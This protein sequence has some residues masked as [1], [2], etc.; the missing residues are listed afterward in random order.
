M[1]WTL[2]GPLG[3]GVCRRGRALEA[4]IRRARLIGAP[5]KRPVIFDH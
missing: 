1:V 3:P 5:L 4:T 2:K